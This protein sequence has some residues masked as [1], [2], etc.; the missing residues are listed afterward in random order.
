M[1]TC[2][3]CGETKPLED[4]YANKGS[5]GGRRADCKAC[6]NAQR[7]ERY[8]ADPRA[9]V[10]RAVRWQRE[11]PERHK[12]KQREYA[13][14]GKKKVADRKS[15]LKRKYGLTVEQYDE[16]LEAQGGGCAI[17]GRLPRGDIALH[18]DHDHET[19]V[20]RGLLCFTCNNALG[21]LEDDPE[22][23]YKAATYLDRDDELTA[24]ALAR[25]RA[26]ALTTSR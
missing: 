16:M 1:K 8:R 12:A 2:N 22:R 4:F 6:N 26:L 11:N 19:G 5:R 25:A 23:L 21:D 13:E 10:E 3:V 20:I 7:R 24:L 14:S 9:H 18:V 15:H 17:C